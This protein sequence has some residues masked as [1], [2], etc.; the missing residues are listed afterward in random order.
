[1]S[2]C[3]KSTVG[4]SLAAALHIPFIDADDLH[5]KANVDKMSNG[6][7]LTDADRTPWLQIVREAAVKTCRVEGAAGHETGVVIACSALRR[8]YRDL[9]RG[10][11]EGEVHHSNE[12]ERLQTYFVFIDGPRD[13]LF[14]RMT[15]RKNHFMKDRMLDSQLAT[16]ESPRGEDGVLVVN[17]SDSKDEQVRS[18]LDSLAKLG[19]QPAGSEH[20]T[21]EEVGHGVPVVIDA[22]ESVDPPAH[23][24]VSPVS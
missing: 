15:Q 10:I 12:P 14:E 3:G 20:P 17:L 18:A 19:V 1:M 2:G 24:N 6:E 23:A 5:P 16:L 22:D 13:V 4:K 7:P 9:L 11:T 8:V 21:R